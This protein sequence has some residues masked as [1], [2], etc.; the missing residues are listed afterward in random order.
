MIDFTA[1]RILTRDSLIFEYDSY[2]NIFYTNDN[3][4]TPQPT[5]GQGLPTDCW[6]HTFL[7][8]EVKVHPASLFRTFISTVVVGY[9]DRDYC[10]KSEAT[11]T[12]HDIRYIVYWHRSHI[13]VKKSLLIEVEPG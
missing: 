3:P 5:K 13:L 12:P 1:Q 6:P 2:L 11:R 10:L 8:T 4:L 7:Q 9:L